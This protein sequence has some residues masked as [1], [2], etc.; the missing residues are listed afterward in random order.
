[1]LREWR[2]GERKEQEYK[3]K[4]REYREVY[5]KKKKRKAWMRRVTEAKTE[6]QVWEVINKDRKRRKVVNEGIEMGEWMEYFME[7]LG[8]VEVRVRR[9][10]RKGRERDNEEDLGKEE[11]ER[12]IRGMED[13]K[14][15]GV[16]G[17][18]SEL[19]K[20]GGEGIRD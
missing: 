11:I 6:G 16:D 13:K 17:I 5:E 14:A 1:M 9:G 7:L 3:R 2:R 4:K 18:A 20:Y 19:W 12:V 15:A 8:G 10:A